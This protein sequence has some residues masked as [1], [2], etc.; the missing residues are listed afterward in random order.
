MA[1]RFFD[2]VPDL[3]GPGSCVV[4]GHRFTSCKVKGNY[5]SVGWNSLFPGTTSLLTRRRTR[6][7]DFDPASCVREGAPSE[8]HISLS[9]SS[10][11]C[12]LGIRSSPLGE[13]SI[14]T[15]TTGR[16]IFIP[17]QFGQLNSRLVTVFTQ[18]TCLPIVLRLR[19]HLYAGRLCHRIGVPES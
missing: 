17:A 16:A 11:S 12:R 14:S 18:K 4:K 7:V 13:S 9:A 2:R 10:E 5:K 8:A 19:L 15:S 6:G 1:L 3:V